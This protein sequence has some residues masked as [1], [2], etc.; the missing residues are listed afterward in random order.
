MKIEKGV[1]IPPVNSQFLSWPFGQMEVG[2]S[3]EV[4]LDKRER[5]RSAVSSYSRQHP[6][7]KFTVQKTGDDTWRCWRTA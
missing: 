2:D 4:P 1:P 6:G 5:C 3:F 7:L